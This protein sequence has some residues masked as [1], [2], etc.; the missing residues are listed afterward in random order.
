VLGLGR[1][2]PGDSIDSEELLSRVR[3]NFKIDVQRRGAAIARRMI[4]RRDTYVADLRERFESPRPQHTNAALATDALKQALATAG[5][6]S[7]DLS[8]VVAHTA[9]PGQLIPPN[10][11]R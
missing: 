9:T 2:L 11:G 6:Q 4:S 10:V 1:S 3:R 7:S 8:Y 5:M